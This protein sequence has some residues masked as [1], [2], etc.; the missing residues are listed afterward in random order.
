MTQLE[1]EKAQLQS[2]ISQLNS[3]VIVLKNEH[4]EQSDS[5][6]EAERRVREKEQVIAELGTVINSQKTRIVGVRSVG[7]GRTIWRS[8]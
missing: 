3:A 8:R 6:I 7:E 4:D 5:V 2:Q 1:G